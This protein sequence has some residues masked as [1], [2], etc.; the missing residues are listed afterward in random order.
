MKVAFRADAS[1]QIGTGHVMRS[2]TLAD[3]LAARGA[4]C[5]FL[6]RGHE[7]SLIDFIRTKGHRVHA[8]PVAP[9]VDTGAPAN[10]SDDD[11]PPHR[12]WLGA[13]QAQDVDACTPQPVRHGEEVAIGHRIVFTEDIGTLK[14]VVLDHRE[15]RLHVLRH[16][17]SHVVERFLL[18]QIGR[19]HV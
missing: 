19:A 13:P 1:L 16:L 2:L 17:C 11:T 8:L 10:D 7:G 15:G 18:L 6:C 12:H 9:L 5:H 3:A 4:Q 14:Q